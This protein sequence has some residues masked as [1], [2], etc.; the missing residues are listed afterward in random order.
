MDTVVPF[1]VGFGGFGFGQP[2]GDFEVFECWQAAFFQFFG[3]QLPREIVNR[4]VRHLYEEGF[5]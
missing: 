4:V 5:F 2:L 1:V 3:R